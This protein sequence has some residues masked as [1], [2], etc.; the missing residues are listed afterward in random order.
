MRI[1]R[2]REWL[3]LRIAPWLYVPY[4]REREQ[5]FQ[6]RTGTSTLSGRVRPRSSGR[7]RNARQDGRMYTR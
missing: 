7:L 5:A 6:P 1:R 4:P 3:A 2:F